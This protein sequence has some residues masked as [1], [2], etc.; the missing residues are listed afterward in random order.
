MKF[1]RFFGKGFLSSEEAVDF[2]LPGQYN[3]NRS[4]TGCSGL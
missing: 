2:N 3:E 1:K 4:Q